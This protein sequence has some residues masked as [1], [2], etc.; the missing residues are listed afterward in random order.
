MSE[1]AHNLNYWAEG[2]FESGHSFGDG[3]FLRR[4]YIE[5][6]GWDMGVEKLFDTAMRPRL[7]AEYM[8]ASGDPNRRHSPTN[9]AGGNRGDRCDTSFVGFGFR[10][11]GISLAPTMS[12]L[13]VWRLGGSLAPLD[14]YE[15]FRDLETLCPEHTILASNTSALLLK[16]IAAYCQRKDRVVIT[17]WVNPPHLVPLVEVVAGEEM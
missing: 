12:N 2:V 9:A 11:T 10:D 6:F 17:H 4:D 5:A 15:L 7:V 16:D 14:R 8:F 13:H 1:L 3:A